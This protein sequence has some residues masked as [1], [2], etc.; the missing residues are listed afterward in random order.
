MKIKWL[1]FF[2]V[3]LLITFITTQ[4]TPTASNSTLLDGKTLV[5]NSC[6]ACHTLDRIQ[7]AHKNVEN[8]KTTVERMVSKGAQLNS[9]EQIMVIDFLAKTYPK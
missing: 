3:L 5:Q 4:C 8:W 1:L 6:S 7:N 2:F 9:A